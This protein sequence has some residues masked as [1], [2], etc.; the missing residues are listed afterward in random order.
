MSLVDRLNRRLAERLRRDA[1]RMIVQHDAILLREPGGKER[2]LPLTTLTRATL[3]HRDVYAA[4]AILLRLAF[5][6]GERV[7][8]FHDDPQWNDLAAGLDRS[9]RIG[10]PSASWQLQ[11]IADGPDAPPRELIGP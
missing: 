6:G 9:G 5:D 3:L 2:R 4:D 11:A 10:T 8:I 1:P 7:E